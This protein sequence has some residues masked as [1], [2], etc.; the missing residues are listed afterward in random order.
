M[1]ESLD[2][3]MFET[4]ATVWLVQGVD[5]KGDFPD[6][7]YEQWP[8]TGV[9]EAALVQVSAPLVRIPAE[10]NRGKFSIHGIRHGIGSFGL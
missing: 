5:V 3:K 8:L 4:L 1:S 7:G 10:A 9:G 6:E 2:E